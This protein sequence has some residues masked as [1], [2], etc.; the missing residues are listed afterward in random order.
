MLQRAIGVIYLPQ[1]ERMS[2]YYFSRLPYQFDGI[3][4]LDTTRALQALQTVSKAA[5]DEFPET[6]PTGM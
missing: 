4:H 2:H 6:Y 5:I 1:T 3:V